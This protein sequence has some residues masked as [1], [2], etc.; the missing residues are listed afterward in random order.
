MP[1]EAPF[2]FGTKRSSLE[3]D[4][5][6]CLDQGNVDVVDLKTNPIRELIERGIIC[7]DGVEREFDTVVMATGFD[8]MTGSLTNMNIQGRDR[9]NFQERWKEGVFTHL[10]LSA[11]A[12][13]T[14]S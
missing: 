10:G 6:E 1:K 8:S 13:R 11:V 9:V 4:Y 12:A 5:Y 14:C 2:A 3:Q 7:Q